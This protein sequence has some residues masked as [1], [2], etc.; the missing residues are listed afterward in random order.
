MQNLPHVRRAYVYSGNDDRT[1]KSLFSSPRE[2]RSSWK[3]IVSLNGT[4]AKMMML[5][6][7]SS[8]VGTGDETPSTPAQRRFRLFC[9]AVYAVTYVVMLFF[10]GFSSRPDGEY[11]MNPASRRD[12]VLNICTVDACMYVYIFGSAV[13]RSA[14]Y[15]VHRRRVKQIH[16]VHHTGWIHVH[17][18]GSHLPVAHCSPHSQL[19]SVVFH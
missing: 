18:L 15:A 2:G 17:H 4:S 11:V 19:V 16:N 10:N 3:Q 13:H 14:D 12:N 1:V 7:W 8:G 9:I 6:A 5:K